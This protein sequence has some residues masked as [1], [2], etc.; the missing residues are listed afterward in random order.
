MDADTGLLLQVLH[1]ISCSF[2][3]ANVDPSSR[4][5]PSP[6]SFLFL[7]SLHAGW[8]PSQSSSSACPS[9]AAMDSSFNLFLFQSCFPPS[10]VSPYPLGL[11]PSFS[12]GSLPSFHSPHLLFLFFLLQ[13][14]PQRGRAFLLNAAPRPQFLIPFFVNHQCSFWH[15]PDF[16]FSPTPWGKPVP[17]LETH[18]EWKFWGI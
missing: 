18:T 6:I 3:S 4:N 16:Y 13:L 5:P 14:C 15:S 10:S 7:S 8:F 1:S 12:P 9:L 2:A 11:G 17:R